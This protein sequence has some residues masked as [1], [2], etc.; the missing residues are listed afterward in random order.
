ME[1]G[2]VGQ[3][4]VGK[5]TLFN[6][7]TL[8]NVPMAPYPF[9]TTR[10]NRGVGAVRIPCPHPEKQTPCVPGNAPCVDGTRWVPVSLLDVPGLVPGAHEGRGL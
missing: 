7:L 4:N 8:L 10:A 5:S 9:T 6:A 2:V 3:P 1:I